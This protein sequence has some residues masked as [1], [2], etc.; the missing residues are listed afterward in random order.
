M[1]IKPIA[2]VGN[3]KANMNKK[4]NDELNKVLTEITEALK[5]ESLT[6]DE[7][8][9]LQ[10]HQAAISG[11]LLSSWLPADNVRKAI[12]FILILLGLRAFANYNDMYFLFWFL[13]TLFSPRIVGTA[14][15]YFGR[16][17]SRFN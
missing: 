16:L 7:R 9:E 14:F 2:L 8:L 15:F 10:K 3:L 17:M 13:A 12:M 4:E 11:A 1:V 6:A 5:D